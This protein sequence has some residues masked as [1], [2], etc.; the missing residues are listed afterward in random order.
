M[1]YKELILKQESKNLNVILKKFNQAFSENEV[2]LKFN[3]NNLLLLLKEVDINKLRR[4]VNN[5]KNDLDTYLFVS[6]ILTKMERIKSYGL[7]NG[8]RNYTEYNKERKVVNRKQKEE[9]R[10]IYYYAQDNNLPNNFENK[11][12]YGDS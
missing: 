3:N 2:Q 6:N 5:Q 11:I 8:K 7:S 1:K 12:I 9:K 10:G 4:F